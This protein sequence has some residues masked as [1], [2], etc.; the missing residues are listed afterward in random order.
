MDRRRSPRVEIE[1]E[2]TLS[3]RNGTPIE[4]RTVDLGPGGMSVKCS[5]PL[6]EDELIEFTIPGRRFDGRARV[7]R[8]QRYHVYAL[9]FEELA[10]AH[11]EQLQ[12]MASGPG[13]PS[14]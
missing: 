12:A 1:L 13:R 9:R 11:R 8:E 14:G 6:A 3:R 5:R 7:L 2:C 10:D 4:A